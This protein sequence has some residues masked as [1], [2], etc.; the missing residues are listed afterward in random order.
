M[1]ATQSSLVIPA[2]LVG[3]AQEEAGL[4]VQPQGV[5]LGELL[6]VWEPAALPEDPVYFHTHGI[7]VEL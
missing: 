1:E 2:L 7:R 5:D 4:D 3:A 6:F